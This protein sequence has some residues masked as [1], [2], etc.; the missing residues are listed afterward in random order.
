MCRAQVVEP[1]AMPLAAMLTN[2]AR[3]LAERD[4]VDPAMVRIGP[5]DFGPEHGSSQQAG[6]WEDRLTRNRPFGKEQP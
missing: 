5:V 3:V 4:G 2:M 1:A 6:S